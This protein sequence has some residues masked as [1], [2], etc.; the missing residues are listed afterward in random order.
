M[1]TELTHLLVLFHGFDYKAYSQV[2]FR[3]YKVGQVCLV[4]GCLPVNNV[5]EKA[6]RVSGIIR[7]CQ[8]NVF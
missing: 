3:S 2:C 8:L 1:S 4:S 7:Y 5:R 6:R